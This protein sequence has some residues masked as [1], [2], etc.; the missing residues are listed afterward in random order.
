MIACKS[1]Q[2]LSGAPLPYCERG[3]PLKRKPL[4]STRGGCVSVQYNKVGL[5]IL[6][7]DKAGSS[8][9]QFLNIGGDCWCVTVNGERR[10]G[11]ALKE[12]TMKGTLWV[13]NPA[14]ILNAIWDNTLQ[15]ERAFVALYHVPRKTLLVIPIFDVYKV[16]V[17]NAKERP[18]KSIK[19]AFDV[20]VQGYRKYALRVGEFKKEIPV[21][22]IQ[23]TS[24]LLKAID[25][26]LQAGAV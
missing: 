16:I 10:L 20:V 25:I 6:L 17:G 8:G 4:D 7:R 11:I 24:P 21:R 2:F 14:P 26:P 5:E 23:D 12:S 13:G 3:L 19:M 22:F 1:R 9:G 15:F 18:D